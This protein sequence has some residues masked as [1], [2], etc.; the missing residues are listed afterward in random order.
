VKSSDVETI[1][2][3]EWMFEGPGR[4]GRIHA[5]LSRAAA[6][7]LLVQTK[8]GAISPGT[9]RTLLHGAAQAVPVA[10]YPHQPGYLNVVTIVDAADR[11]LLGDRGVAVLGHRDYALIPEAKFIRIPTGVPDEL[12]LLG[13]LAADARH[14][15][16]TADPRQ[17]EECLV[18]GGGIL[19]VLTAWELCIRIRGR[20]LL[21]E[22]DPGR[23]ELLAEIRWPGPVTIADH[24]GRRHHVMT[25]FD[26]ASTASAFETVQHAM[27]RHGSILLIADGGHEDYVL[28]AEF[29]A[30]E[31][32]LGKTG[33]HPN[34]RGF[35]GEYFSRIDDRTTLLDAA[36]REDVRFCDF[37]KAYLETLLTP[38]TQSKGLL[39]RVL[40]P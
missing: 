36:F 10:S 13:V 2:T 7:E 4:L 12:A 5:T 27:K 15:I 21:V 39:P 32:F 26:C 37:P 28:S 35:L 40:Y 14:A 16:E 9:E 33:S 17:G 25:A 23:R 8:V 3:T 11:T 30:K 24:V 18:V 19:G 31:L 29:F 20:V 22:T 1:R 34:L 38:S 6:G